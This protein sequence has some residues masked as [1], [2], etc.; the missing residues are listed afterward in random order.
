MI[1]SCLYH[2]PSYGWK[3]LAIQ[4]NTQS[5]LDM[6]A[7]RRS[8]Q[9]IFLFQSQRQCGGLGATSSQERKWVKKSP[10][11]WLLLSLQP[12]AELYQISKRRLWFLI[13]RDQFGEKL[14]PGIFSNEEYCISIK[15]F[16][17]ICIYR[18]GELGEH[19]L[20]AKILFFFCKDS[21]V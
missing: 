14:R 11:S 18:V 6:S 4:R 17:N 19:L 12:S 20:Q 3:S 13:K 1:V 16:K 8:V 5:T 10:S 21:L 2:F 15:K 7:C 9:G